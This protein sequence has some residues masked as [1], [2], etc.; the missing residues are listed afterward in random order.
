[1]DAQQGDY[2]TTTEGQTY[3][4][5]AWRF[6]DDNGYGVILNDND[7]VIEYNV[8]IEVL[9]PV[10]AENAKLKEELEQLRKENE[11]LKKGRLWCDEEGTTHRVVCE[12]PPSSDEDE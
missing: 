10:Y 9:H 1:M 5:F 4:V 3:E 6:V 7:E 11:E 2:Y 12:A 8:D